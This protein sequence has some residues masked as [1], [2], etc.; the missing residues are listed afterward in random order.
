MK[1]LRFKD[2]KAVLVPKDTHLLGR[3]LLV[4]EITSAAKVPYVY[5]AALFKAEKY[6]VEGI[7]VDLNYQ[8]PKNGQWQQARFDAFVK[9]RAEIYRELKDPYRTIWVRARNTED[10]RTFRDFLAATPAP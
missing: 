6:P 5:M 10:I 9:A 2:G 4:P 7:I 8:N 1:T 3:E